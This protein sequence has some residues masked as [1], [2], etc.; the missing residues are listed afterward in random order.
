MQNDQSQLKLKKPLIF[1]LSS[2]FFAMI[3]ANLMGKDTAILVGNL[4]YIP[5]T[6]VLT[7]LSSIMAIR[8]RGKS[9]H[10]I[11]WLMFLVC[12][13][14]WMIAEYVWIAEE[15]VYHVNP[16]PSNADIFYVIG[17]VFLILFSI[18]YM[19][20]VKGSITKR[21]ILVSL[22]ISSSLLLPSIYMTQSSNSDVHGIGFALALSYPILDAIVLVPAIIGILLFFKGEVSR[23]WTFFSLAIISLVAGDTGFLLTQMNGTYYTGHP[24]EIMLNWS[25][26]LFSFGVYSQI[27]I[28]QSDKNSLRD[29]KSL[30]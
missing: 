18:N 12:A 28:F 1:G 24:I 4:G 6:V 19:K 21:M 15:L 10:G 26:I 29:K 2:I 5:V 17:Y 9:Q 20:I 11:A 7:I 14:S 25:Y 16:F 8:F 23:L 30:R 13:S 3:I 27:K 22:V